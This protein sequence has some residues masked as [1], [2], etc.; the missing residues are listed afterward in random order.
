MTCSNPL[1]APCPDCDGEVL[2]TSPG[3]PPR[4]D[5]LNLRHLDKA[6]G[7]VSGETVHLAK[8]VL[9]PQACPKPLMVKAEVFRQAI[10]LLEAGEPL[11][12]HLSKTLTNF[13][14]SEVPAALGGHAAPPS[15]VDDTP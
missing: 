3:G 8:H 13:R 4:T 1:H 6:T 2:L 15:P 5:P 11:T 10:A 12:P 7:E 9:S 14:R